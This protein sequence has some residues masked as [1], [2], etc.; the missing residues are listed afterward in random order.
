MCLQAAPP[1]INVTSV[2]FTD[3]LQ[4]TTCVRLLLNKIIRGVFW[5]INRKK[6]SQS[7]K[8][9]AEFQMILGYS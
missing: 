7:K 6:E 1:L 3:A 5:V 9:K 4:T 2:H 8:W